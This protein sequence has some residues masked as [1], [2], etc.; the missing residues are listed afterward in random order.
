MTRELQEELKL[1]LRDIMMQRVGERGEE[2]GW[3]GSIEE[4]EAEQE[5]LVGGGEGG[6]EALEY[7]ELERRMGEI[8]GT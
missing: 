7:S 1:M 5:S 8:F 6:S 4:M 2:E 3:R